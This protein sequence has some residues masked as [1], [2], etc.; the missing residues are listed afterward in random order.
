M[1][2]GAESKGNMARRIRPAGGRTGTRRVLRE[3]IRDLVIDDILNDRL[4]PGDRL[5][6]TRLAHR[7]SVSQA[8]VR[9]A[10]RDLELLGFVVSFPFR[11][12]IVRKISVEDL[13]QIYP[14]R[15]ALEGVA[16]HEAATRIT[17]AELRRLRR[18]LG[19][20]RQAAARADTRA[21][22]E[23]DLAFHLT[24]VDASGNRPLRQLWERLIVGTT[25]FLTL[26]KSHRSLHEI[27]ER[28]VHVLEPLQARDAAAAES[29]MR[30]HIEEPGHWL[31][32]S[33]G[34]TNLER[35]SQGPV[36]SV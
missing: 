11:G 5:I 8:P 12:T 24:I 26:M 14:I 21:Q 9:E 20:M 27:A 22:V 13:V 16:A 31:R 7:F 10:L 19:T 23:A 30:L 17:A 29:A 34:T 32:E 36:L 35:A 1:N 2:K 6:E 4:T 3:H 28:H 15:A 25:T 33:L 18:L